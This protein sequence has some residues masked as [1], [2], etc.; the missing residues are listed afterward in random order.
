MFLG[1]LKQPTTQKTFFNVVSVLQYCLPLL[2]FIVDAQI[3]ILFSSFLY[4]FEYSACITYPVILLTQFSILLLL[5]RLVF[6]WWFLSSTPACAANTK[7]Q[8][9]P[10]VIILT[11]FVITQWLDY[12]VIGDWIE[13]LLSLSNGTTW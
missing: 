9:I 8:F 5:L 1:S 12:V 3:T 10:V 4:S 13:L 11:V 7:L 2:S 6:W